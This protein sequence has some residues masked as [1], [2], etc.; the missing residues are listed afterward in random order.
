MMSVTVV[1][2]GLSRTSLPDAGAACLAATAATHV[3]LIGP[4]AFF[5]TP[6]I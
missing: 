3:M 2:L 5:V 1:T 6:Q 4:K